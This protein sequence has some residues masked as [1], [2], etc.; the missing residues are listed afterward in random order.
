MINLIMSEFGEN[1]VNAGG[2]SFDLGRLEP[3]LTSFGAY[4]KDIHLTIYTD[5]DIKIDTK[6]PYTIKKVEPIS[7]G[8]SR[9]GYHNADYYKFK[10]LLESKHEYAIAV[11]SDMLVINYDVESLLPITKKFGLCFPQNPRLLVNNDS[12]RGADSNY[13]REEDESK[14]YGMALNISPISFYTK[15]KNMRKVL[16][17]TCEM[18]KEKLGRG[19]TAVWRAS[20]ELGIHPY[21]LPLQW[22]VC[23]CGLAK[24]NS[25]YV[26]EPI[27]L[28]LGHPK[29]KEEYVKDWLGVWDALKENYEVHYG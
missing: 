28:H 25:M 21:V 9:S 2:S 22:C 4:F 15:N 6:I 7:V 29:V 3:T 24:G 11:D 17:K 20:W 16:E 12:V 5:F 26:E 8:D 19:T 1:R 14:G 13:T 27:I 18:L 10:G 23:D